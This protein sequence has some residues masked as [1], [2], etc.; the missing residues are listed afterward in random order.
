MLDM[1]SE[2]GML[3]YRAVEAPMD[4]NSKLLPD[5]GVSRDPAKYRQLM[6]KSTI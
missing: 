4:S 6:G 1:L 5:Q 3:R 2:S